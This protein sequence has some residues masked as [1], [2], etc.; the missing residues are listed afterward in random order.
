MC[1]EPSHELALIGAEPPR[2]PGDLE[3]YQNKN[4]GPE[5]KQQLCY[6]NKALPWL[7]GWRLKG[8][9]LRWGV[10]TW[11]MPSVGMELESRLGQGGALYSELGWKYLELA[12]LFLSRD[13]L[14]HVRIH[15]KPEMDRL[16][17]SWA[18]APE[19]RVWCSLP[20]HPE[21]HLEQSTHSM[22]ASE[23]I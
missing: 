14:A 17:P 20:L 19:G 12:L 15:A 23:C 16:W 8:P 4:L 21:K 11:V 10:S 1:L 9:G 2:V 22:G 6:Q 3:R 13:S 18:Q 5:A 7:Q